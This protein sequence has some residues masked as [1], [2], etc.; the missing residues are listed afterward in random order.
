MT[1]IYLMNQMNFT[2]LLHIIFAVMRREENY[3][4]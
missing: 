4:S 1:V 3:A 2:G